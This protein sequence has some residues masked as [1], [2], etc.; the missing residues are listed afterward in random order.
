MN[1]LFAP[2]RALMT[3]RQKTKHLMVG[4]FFCVPLAISLIVHPP[5]WTLAAAAIALTF[6]F[7]LYFLAALQYSTDESW[8]EIHQVAA[9]LGEHDLR[10]SELPRADAMTSVNR[11]G[12][13]QMGRH[14]KRLVGVHASMRDVVARVD[15]SVRL[16]RGA[17]MDLSRGSD[18][19]S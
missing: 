6:A 8:D 12:T 19:L 4:G 11:R 1:L 2:V 3:G 16:T 14:Y 5:G 9:L 18:S 7:S 17:A 15:A 10:A 13:G